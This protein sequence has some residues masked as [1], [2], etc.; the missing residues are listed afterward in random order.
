MRCNLPYLEGDEVRLQ[1]I[2]INLV[3]NALKFTDQGYIHILSS[4]DY[5]DQLLI[6]HVR[7]TGKGIEAH[8][9][10][11]LFKRYGKLQ[12]EFTPKLNKDGIGLGLAICKAIIE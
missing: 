7:D 1:Q 5:I 9:I 4:Y 8:D 11:N 3:K 2:L 6:I 12:T 10:K